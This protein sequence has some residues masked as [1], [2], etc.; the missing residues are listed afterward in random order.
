[1]SVESPN[2]DAMTVRTFI[3]EE[4]LNGRTVKLDDHVDLI[5][6]GIIDSLSLLRLVTFLE[7]NCD[8][9]VQDEEIVPDNFRTLAAIQ[10]FIAKRKAAN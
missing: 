4:L 8:V 10:S 1:M 9:Q 7:E 2:S 5:E 6:E 3:E